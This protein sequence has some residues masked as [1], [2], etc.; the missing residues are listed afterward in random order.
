MLYMMYVLCM[1]FIYFIYNLY[2][3][4]SDDSDDSTARS[5]KDNEVQ[6][7][8]GIFLFVQCFRRI[9]FHFRK[10]KVCK[11]IQAY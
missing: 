5:E 1:Y 11:R 3:D 6:V 10:G 7:G 4:D 2:P 8:V 9:H